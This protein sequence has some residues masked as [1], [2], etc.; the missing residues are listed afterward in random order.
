MIL[1]IRAHDLGQGSAEQLARM[2]AERGLQAVHLAPGKALQPPLLPAQYNPGAAWQIAQAFARQG[3][4]IAVLGCYINPVHPDPAVRRAEIARF[5]TTLRH[6]RD[7]GCSVVA[8]ETGSRN[9]DC[10][11]HPDNHSETAFVELLV[12]MQE[13]VL[14][15]EKWGVTIALEAAA[16]HVI[17]DFPRLHRLLVALDSNHAQ[18]LLDPVNVMTAADMHNQAEFFTRTLALLGP[19][20]VA[21]HAKDLVLD[22]EGVRR[23]APGQGQIDYADLLRRIGQYMPGLPVLMEETS[24]ADMAPALQYLRSFDGLC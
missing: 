4:Q 15:A 7:F 10:S 22:G 5:K 24:G 12:S 17:H 16:E 20:L 2:A 8:T 6:A 21:M 11:F 23:V 19:R 1:G 9:A 14:E 13:L 18:V 3:V